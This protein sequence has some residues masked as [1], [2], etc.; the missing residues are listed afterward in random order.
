MIKVDKKNIDDIYA[1]TPMQEGIL[2]HYLKDPGSDIYFEQLCLEIAGEI[3]FELFEKAWNFVIETNEMLRATFRWEKIENPIQVI[4]KKHRL[5]P[6]YHDL[7]GE[8]SS[9]K[10]TR[11]EN[12]K[13]EDRKEKFDLREVPFRVTLCRVEAGKYEMIISNHHI[14]YDGWSTG[15]IIRE[16]FEAYYGQNKK[17]V[18]GDQEAKPTIK[19]SY[20]EFIQWIQNQ[21]KT[22]QKHYWKEYLARFEHPTGLLIKIKRKKT[23]ELKSSAN[24]PVLLERSIKDRLEIFIKTN[25]VTLAAFFYSAWGILLQAYG[26]TDDV[27]FGTTV[28]GRSAR[29]KG[30]EDM[31]GLFINTI[32]LRVRTAPG[33]KIIDLVQRIN[34]ILPI[35]EKYESTPLVDIKE[36]SELENNRELFDSI[37]ALENYPLYGELMRKNSQSPLAV[38]SYSMVESTNY[39]LGIAIIFGKRIEIDY[40]YNPTSFEKSSIT[41]LSRHFS[42]IIENILINTKN[43]ISGIEILSGEEKKQILYNFNDTR[44]AYPKNKTIHGLFTRQTERTPDHTALTAG[45]E[46]TRGLAPLQLA[47][48]Q[49]AP[50][51]STTISI[52]YRELNEKSHR[53]AQRLKAKGVAADTIVGLMFERSLEMIIGIMGILKAGGAFLPVDT[54]YPAERKTF[55]LHDSN[56]HILLTYTPL[57]AEKKFKFNGEMILLD[58]LSVP[59]GVG[60]NKSTTSKYDNAGGELAYIMYTSGS[61]GR[62]KGVMATHRNVVRLVVN[63]NYIRL[64]GETRILQTGAPVFDATTFEIWGALL[65]GGR[66]VLV[67]KEVILDAYRLDQA[68]RQNKINTLWLTSPLFNRLA[69]ENCDIFSNLDYLLVGGDVLSPRYINL[70]RSKSKKL[71]IINGYGPTENT[72]FSTT[73]L[74]DRDFEESIPI[75]S[76]IANSTAFV[77]DR[78]GKPQPVGVF[79]ELWVGGDGV[80]RGYLNNPE[81]TAD[82]FVIS[83]LSSV[84]ESSNKLSTNDRFYKTGD[85]ARWLPDGNIDFLGRID[86]QTKIRGYRVE[87]GEIESRLLSYPTVKEAVVTAGEGEDE[88]KYLCAYLVLYPGEHLEKEEL[89]SHLSLELP[90]YMV[91]P[92]FVVLE[93]MPLT[94]NGKVDRKILPKPDVTSDKDHIPPRDET[95][96]LVAEIWAQVLGID[97][98]KISIDDNFFRLGGHSLKAASLCGRIYKALSVEIPIGELFERPTIE[99]ISR[100]IA[101]AKETRY[102]SIE[103]VEEKEYYPLSS[104]QKRLFLIYQMS[105]SGITYNLTGIMEVQGKLEKKRFEE[106]FSRLITRHESLRTSFEFING[107][108]V[109]EIHPQVEFEIKYDQS[110]VNGHWSLGNCQG[111]GEIPS[112]IKVEKI[113]RD[114]IRPFDLSQAPLLRVGMIK[115][116]EEKHLLLLDMHHI[117]SDG[118]SMGIFIKEFTALYRG[119]ESLP[120]LYVQYKDFS[121]WQNNLLASPGIKKQEA[122]WLHQFAGDIPVLELPLDYPRA[123]VQQFIGNQV[124]FNLGEEKTRE[125]NRFSR[126]NDS[127]L[128]IVLLAVSSLLLSKLSSQE[129]IVVGTPTAG[130][131]HHDLEKLI[132]MFVNTLALRIDTSG[133]KTLSEFIKDIRKNFLTTFENQD[134]PYEA[135]VDRVM[136]NVTRDLGRNPL[137]DVMVVVQNMEMEPVKLPGLK[138]TPYQYNAKITRFDLTLICIENQGKLE[139]T[140]EYSSRL[141]T[142]STIQRYIIYFKELLSGILADKNRDLFELEII[143][144][145]EKQQILFDFNDTRVK[146]PGEYKTLHELF[147]QVAAR[148]PHHVSVVGSSIRPIAQG[149]HRSTKSS[150]ER[151]VPYSMRGAITYRELNK[152][153][154][155]LAYL[156]KQKGVKSGTIVAMMIPRSI[157]M[158]V[159]MLA[160]LKSGGAYL[161]IDPDYPEARVRYML[162]DSAAELLIGMGRSCGALNPG[163]VIDLTDNDKCNSLRSSDPGNVTTPKNLLYVIYT[164]GSTGRPKGA[165]VKHSGFV[166]LVYTHQKIFKEGPG[167]RMSQAAGPGFDAMAFEVWPCLLNSGT[168]FIAAD[169]TRSDPRKMKEW[170]IVNKITISFQP[171]ILAEHLLMEQW[172]GKGVALRALMTAGEQLTR[173]PG[174]RHPFR[175]YNLYGPTE[176]TVWSTWAEVE[177]RTHQ[178]S[179]KYPFIGQ[180]IANHRVYIMGP[181][182]KLQPIGVPGEIC[183]AGEGVAVGY[184]NRPELTSEKFVEDHFVPDERMYKSGDLARWVPGDKTD[185]EFLGRIDN[186]VKIRGF[187]IEPG[188]I[189]STLLGYGG[190]KETVVLTREDSKKDKYLCAYIVP[191]KEISLPGMRDYLS[192]N[193]PSYMVPSYFAVLKKMPLTL[194]GKIDRKALPEPEIA[195]TKKYF[196]PRNKKEERLVEIWSE[197]LGI[198]K[199]RIS[200][201]DDFFQLGG[202]SLKATTLATR[203]H[204]VIHVKLPLMEIFNRPT[205]RRLSQYIKESVEEHYSPIEAIEEKEYYLLSPAQRRLYFLHRLDETA[206]AYNISCTWLLEGLLDKEK[207]E[208]VFRSLIQRHE[209]FRTSFLIIDEEPAQRIHKYFNFEIVYIDSQIARFKVKVEEEEGIEEGRV[210]GWKGRRVEEKKASFGQDLNAYG[211]HNHKGQELRAKSYISSFIRPFDLS[212]APLIRVG[213]LE[214][215]KNKHIFM[216]DMHHI[217]SD[218]TSAAVLVKEFMSLY[219]GEA[220]PPLR[221]RYKDFSQWQN[222]EP[223]KKTLI[224]QESYWKRQFHG[225]IPVLDLP[226][227]YPRP[228]MQQFEGSRVTFKI[229]QEETSALKSLALE[230]NTTLYMMLLAIYY[231]FLSKLTDQEDIMIGTPTAGRHHADLEPIIGMFVNTLVLRNYP[232]GEKTYIGFLN[233]VKERS[234]QAFENQDYP[235]ETLVEEVSV[236]RDASRNPLFDTMFVMQ[237]M[238]IPGIEIPGLRLVPYDHPIEIS[239]FD[240]TLIGVE[241]GK[242]LTFIFEYSTHLFKKAS[243]ERFIGYFSRI[244]PVV[245]KNREIKISGIEIISEL[246]KQRVLYELND[247]E[248]GYPKDK[249]IHRLFEVQAARNPDKIAI[250]AQRIQGIPGRQPRKTHTPHNAEKQPAITYK[251]LNERSNQLARRLRSKGVGGDTMVGIMLHRSI[252]AIIG[253]LAVLKAGGAFLP[254]DPDYPR[255]RKK[256]ISEDSQIKIMLTQGNLLDKNGNLFSFIS[257]GNF[258]FI[259]KKTIYSGKASNLKIVNTVGSIA[260][261]IYTSGSTGNPKGVMVENRNIVN[262]ICW[263]INQYVQHQR[264]NFPFFTSLSFDL[265][266]TS[267]FTPLLSGNTIIVYGDEIKE[268]LIETIIEENRAEAVKL[269]PSHLKLILA[270]DNHQLLLS[271]DEN[272]SMISRFIVGGESLETTLARGISGKFK[273]NPVIYNEYGPTETTIG[274]M[275]YRFSP[276]EPTGQSVPIGL[277]AGNIQIYLLDKNGKIVPPGTRGEICISGNGV[278]RGYLNR[279]ELTANRFIDNP[280]APRRRMYRSGDLGR[281]LSDGNIEFLGR[282]DRQVK[283]RGFRI[284]LEEIEN[285]LREHK[286]IKDAVV[287]VKEVKGEQYLCAYMVTHSKYPPQPHDSASCWQGAQLRDYLSGILPDYMIPSFFIFLEAIP[288]T[289]NGKIDRKA[290]PEPGFERGEIHVSPRNQV[291]ERLAVIWAEVLG[292][293]KNLIGIDSN[294]FRLGGHSLKV[295]AVAAKIYKT[296]NLK[297]PLQEIF[298]QPTIRRLSG[299]IEAAVKEQYLSIEAAEKKEYYALSSVQKRL[300]FLQQM[301]E[302]AAAYNMPTVWVLEGIIDKDKLENTIRGLIQRHESLRTSFIMVNEEAVQQTH[303]EVEFGIE[304]K[305]L[306]VKV[307]VEVEGEAAPF[308]QINSQAGGEVSSPIEIGTITRGFIRPF[309]LSRAPL[310]RVGLTKL[311]HTT[312]PFRG[313]PSPGGKADRYL[314]MVD[315]HHIIADGISLEVL[316]QDF[317]ALYAGLGLPVLKLRYKDYAQWQQRELKGTKAIEEQRFWRKEFEGEVPVLGIPYDFPR[318]PIQRFE[319]SHLDFQIDKE[320]VDSLRSLALEKGTTLFIVLLALYTILLS[321]LSNQENIIIGTPVA[322]RKHVDTEKI[323]GMFVNTLAMRNYPEGEKTFREFLKEVKEKTLAALENQDYPLENLVEEIVIDRDLSRNPLFDV[324][325]V[326]Q[327]EGISTIDIPGLKLRPCECET[328]ISKFDLTFSGVEIGGR[329]VFSVEFNTGLFLTTTIQRFIDYFKKIV[330][331][332][333]DNTGI[334]IREIEIISAEE[335][336]QL[337]YGFNDTTSWYPKG[338]TIHQLF[339]NQ[340]EQTPERVALVGKE[341]GW[342]DRRVEGGKKVEESFDRIFDAYSVG[343]LSY[344]ELNIKAN[345]L[346]HLLKERG[347]KPDTVVGLMLERS[348]EMI[349]G[350][351]GILKAGGGYLPI[352]PGYPEERIKY[353]LKDSGAEILVTAHGLSEKFEKLLIVNC[354]LLIVNEIPPDRRRFNNPPKEANPV[355]NYRLT[356]NNL[357]LEWTNLAYIIY[358]SGSTGR[359]KGVMVEH[360]SVVNLA[361]S[362]KAQFEIDKNDRV[363]Q[364]STICFD[365]SVEQIFITLFSGA[366]LVLVDRDTLL[367]TRGFDAFVTRLGITHIHAVPSFLSNMKL[368]AASIST[369]KRV[370][371]GGDECPAMLAK[372]WGPHCDF[373]NEYGPTETT[374]TSIEMLVKDVDDHARRLPIGKPINNTICYLL[375]SRMYLVPLG[376]GGEVYI[377]GDG[378]ARGY[379]NRPELTAEKFSR[380][381][382]GYQKFFRGSRGAILQ[383]SPPG[384]RRL[385]K[386]GDLARWLPEGY[387]EFLGRV[388]FQVK[389]RGFRIEIGEIEAHLL[390]HPLVSAAIV[391]A[392][393]TAEKE[394][395]LCAYIQAKKSGAIES[396]VW[397]DYLSRYLPGY[398]I[399]TYFVQL[400]KI[401]FTSSGKV[402]R[403]AL[404]APTRGIGDNYVAP[405]DEIEKKLVEIWSQVLEREEEKIGIDDNFFQLGGNSI[406]ATQLTARIHRVFNLKISLGELF[407][408]PTIRG[409]ASTISKTEETLFTGIQ[410]VEEKDFYE[411]SFNQKRL[412]FIQQMDPAG[413]AFNMPGRIILNHHVE[414][415]W[416]EKVLV[417]MSHRHESLRSGFI[418][419]DDRPVQRLIKEAPIPLKKIDISSLEGEEKQRKREEIFKETA[420]TSFDLTKAPL[421]RAVLL[422]LDKQMYEFMFNMHHI[423]T[424]GWSMEIIKRDFALLYEGARIGKTVA[425]ESIP[426]QYK[427]FVEWYNDW[428]QDP[429]PKA[430]SHSFWKTKLENGIPEFKIPGDFTNRRESREGAGYYCIIEKDITEKI[431]RLAE[432][433]NTTLFVAMFSVYVLLLSRLSGEQEVVCSIIGAGREHAS[434]HP[435][436]GFFVNSIIYRT[437][438]DFRTPF[439]NFLERVKADTLELFR[440]QDYPLEPVFEELGMR[441]PEISV[442]FN[443]V[444]FGESIAAHEW[445]PIEKPHAEN[446]IE[447]KF[448]L[449]PYITEYKNGLQI[450]WSYKKNLFRPETIAYIAKEYIQ[451]MDYFSRNPGESYIEYRKLNTVGKALSEKKAYPLT[452]DLE[453]LPLAFEPQVKKNLDRLAIKVRDAHFTYDELN[454]YASR[455]A[456]LIEK[457][458]KRRPGD[459]RFGNERVGL[460]FEHGY[461]MIAAIIGTLK[462]GK[463]YVPLSVSYPVKR[464]SYMLSDSEASLIL[465]N[466][467]NIKLAAALT[468]ENQIGIGD[469]NELDRNSKDVL[470]EKPGITGDSPA[471][472]LYTSGST[473]N[474]K[475]V[476]QNHENVLYYT[477]NWGR[478]FSISIEDRMTLFTSFCHDGSVQDMFGALLNGA[479]LYPYDMKNREESALD[480]SGFLN[481]EKITIWHSVPSL[482]GYF[483]NNFPGTGTFSRLRFILLGGEPLRAHEVAMAG[484]Y[485]PNTILANIYG[486][487]ESSVSSIWLIPPGDSEGFPKVIIGEPLDNTGIVLM[488]EDQNIVGPLETGEI[489]VVCSHLALGY[490]KNVEDTQKAFSIHPVYGKMYRTGDMGR[491]LIDGNIEFSGRK[492]KQVKIRGFRIELGEIESWLL[493]HEYIDEAVVKVVETGDESGDKS[494]CAYIVCHNPGV[495]GMR[496]E[497]LSAQLKVYL[498][499]LLPDYMIPTYFIRLERLPLTPGGKLDRG[500]LP[501]PE[502]GKV[503][504]GTFVAPRTW[505]EIKLLEI[506][507][508]VLKSPGEIG[509]EDDF[510]QLGGHSLKAT[511][512]ISRIHKALDVQVP[513]DEFFKRPTI[514]ELSGYINKVAREKYTAIVPAEAKEY[515]ELSPAQKRLY[516]IHQLDSKSTAYNMFTAILIRGRLQCKKVEIVFRKLGR[517]H[518]SLRT[519]FFPVKNKPMQKIIDDMNRLEFA[520]SYFETHE[521]D[522]REISREFIRGF[523]LREAPLMR[524]GLV[525]LEQEKHLL[526][527]DIHHL[528][529]DGFSTT[530]LTKEFRRLYQEEELPGLRIQYKDFGEWQNKLMYSEEMKK[531]EN[532]WLDIFKE[533]PPL[534]NLPVD[535][536]SSRQ[537]SFEGDIILFELD[538]DITGKVYELTKKNQTTVFMVLIAVYYILLAKYTGLEDIVVGTKLTG[539][540]HPDLHHIVGMFV[541]MLALR[542]RPQ[543]NKTFA[544]FLGEVKKNALEAF[545]NQDYP[546]Q[547]L[548]RKVGL[549]GKYNRNPLFDTVFALLNVD[550][551]KVNLS[552]LTITP[553]SL[554]RQTSGFDLHLEG[555]EDKDKGKIIMN[556]GY[557]TGRFK[558]STAE[559]LASRYMEILEQVIDHA[560][561]Q[562]KD[563]SVSHHLLESKAVTLQDSQGDFQF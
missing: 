228:A 352:D 123:S 416:I 239:K 38:N 395:Y 159:G 248:V 6:K 260:Y 488:D 421:F 443:M 386:T 109:Q 107:E 405:G 101:R 156:L 76:P 14:L 535:F 420:G 408:I 471:Y 150:D 70:V 276:T 271:G 438:A 410:K 202:H 122:Y 333:L 96:N 113:I 236:L 277:P 72:T 166:N 52:T 13:D 495:L 300:Y 235:Y 461:D 144:G 546:F 126:E 563:I 177:A 237:H 502:I 345:Q 441:Y 93:K 99:G 33:E 3:D 458:S 337:L 522:T 73:F 427:D 116:E 136:T 252:E 411:L 2:F 217:V 439:D 238:G 147:E 472:I 347:V 501:L 149:S 231:I 74:I 380:Y 551:V 369:L 227:D 530:I 425:L 187:R 486:Q 482:F 208:H 431:R 526:M 246:E 296:F 540:T 91:P 161:P 160:I 341:E 69:L 307:K 314:L 311:L 417:Q 263:S 95:E 36:Y 1:L 534:L 85:L 18:K 302:N 254:L 225:E 525:K 104:P 299:Y 229:D 344:K 23:G 111:E 292:I 464:L 367:D 98:K 542:N 7:S 285:R 118:V 142:E 476:I 521:I 131:S 291:E 244:I 457:E 117:I 406:K 424:D 516:F 378:V 61:T 89:R 346:A 26:N 430:N 328:G 279:P 20:K 474:P 243:I 539:R 351:L 281:Y 465:T 16:F 511:L 489:I 84:N 437:H 294:F 188:E 426:V 106:C 396:S 544:E 220:F 201:D 479:V 204:K 309:D 288:L 453:T 325:L 313:R 87:P 60:M 80:S 407:I 137:F 221:L 409:I 170:L 381:L 230:R 127:T 392:W 198:E 158:I 387:I 200:I 496:I 56:T 71:K 519:I 319:G 210:E 515:Y 48:M 493:K 282:I 415:E 250:T 270:Q 57:I 541:N 356:I 550:D 140:I 46:G 267:I 47:P 128:F 533:K 115:I 289:P 317:M 189:E 436:V 451:L 404:P 306:E 213:L 555:Q 497:V 164:S 315:M 199:E 305:E 507:R 512:L 257:P 224:S 162:T 517:R 529:S 145:K 397:R 209:S 547:E 374:V 86:H 206:S 175:L 342:K 83:H 557:S 358:T 43:E 155:R 124:S 480:L 556:L 97:K 462:A 391:I 283:I 506:W 449:E 182:L 284:E 138:I 266:I 365:A 197:V 492:D 205:I 508:D 433:H 484:K 180:P 418:I 561:I 303:D 223:Q 553:Y 78:Y 429:L 413:S 335:R 353:M 119:G 27:I 377:G 364:F 494:L 440:H 241:T 261:V 402:D 169:E 560:E 212:K 321:K 504:R 490:W 165:A 167:E 280:F 258:L 527:I 348:L 390:K 343:N 371:A 338:L 478:V 157:E 432:R 240:L 549:W 17:I 491:L 434:L 359:P 151:H 469:V 193:L 172:P 114:F 8:K 135:L 500:A 64:N 15:V 49:P 29:I 545:E 286:E 121:H 562:L 460:L 428:W 324:V 548:V 256:F 24:Y 174:P 132:G 297:L 133:S 79:G 509:I 68:I 130:R 278:A 350:I 363:L 477:H 445:E 538:K 63:P 51:L 322:G 269:T 58:E 39:D 301:D 468:E 54:D 184:L 520:I 141:F 485:F 298:R 394:K 148:V 450:Y 215:E 102:L 262:Y 19:L 30:I 329:L 473:G 339:E 255:Q 442:T 323:M 362:Q 259:E 537:I 310:L 384:R 287:A 34:Y 35:R 412:W 178:H 368:T 304:N 55:M 290:L 181:A 466:T 21:D 524:I 110:L 320:T 498:A 422:K 463:V 448:D 219:H 192:K 129:D 531:Q 176:D 153:A 505:I 203:I 523:D 452:P 143:P 552:D 398:M 4:L 103:I 383:K 399:P 366:V 195:L 253:L 543:K 125:L 336:R 42:N 185:I 168:L 191:D 105:P 171:T 312:S 53:L 273:G 295:T 334:K 481:K 559:K 59:E 487:T 389:I 139:F 10:K 88:E 354:Q 318:P 376:V 45:S 75:G 454:R 216:V 218:G 435:I 247:T 31:V 264:I 385:Y 455:I 326:L 50:S 183:I 22:K 173:Y 327:N 77:L 232:L 37:I 332:V 92:Y 207:W 214:I 308:R 414:D 444:S 233:E 272:K 249:L 483:L 274:C 514:R 316:V 90:D 510:F 532:Y 134:Y 44:A 25:R 194:N 234:L 382:W 251:E 475:G 163:R 373:Y 100:Y 447:V 82:K 518:E 265:T 28:S 355:N 403:K 62:P 499:E 152:N 154:N 268:S 357:Q 32:P 419:I 12:L 120:D 226:T 360:S 330:T 388:D 67:E 400:E 11:V 41:R 513:L 459:N 186:Q 361:Y 222:S 349:T 393:K 293:E 446:Y 372:Q 108:P 245:L 65:N 242:K 275:I 470:M 528:I 340:V 112:P 379:L 146:Y 375:D 401:P 558:R 503:N 370:I 179:E 536:P 9:E 554:I 81:L 5:Q 211:G 40:I 196:A 467:K 66:L 456:C 94:T 190:I 331:E 423:I